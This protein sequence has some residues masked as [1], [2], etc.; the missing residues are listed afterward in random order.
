MRIVIIKEFEIA[1]AFYAKHVKPVILGPHLIRK[2]KIRLCQMWV[3]YKCDLAARYKSGKSLKTHDGEKWV[4]LIEEQSK[5]IKKFL[6]EVLNGVNKRAG[7]RGDQEN[8]GVGGQ[9]DG[10]RGGKQ[11]APAECPGA[12]ECH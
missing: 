12:Q 10:A 8:T 4:D 1:N 11:E 6:E 3:N 2:E 5:E 9:G 7:N